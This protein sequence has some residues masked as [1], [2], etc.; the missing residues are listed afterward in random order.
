MITLGIKNET[1]M[2]KKKNTFYYR[3]FIII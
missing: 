3:Y 1:I 2:I